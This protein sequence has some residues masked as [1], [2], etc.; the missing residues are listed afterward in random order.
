MGKKTKRRYDH[1]VPQFYLRNFSSNKSIGFYNFKIKKFVDKVAIHDIGGRNYFNGKDIKLEKWFIDLE[2]TWTTIFNN[3]LLHEKVPMDSTEY[4]YLLMFVY[5]SDVRVAEKADNFRIAKSEEGRNLAKMM[6][7]QNKITLSDDEI[8]NLDVEIDMP[9]LTYI[10]GMK[11]M[12]QILSDLCPLI[13][14]NESRIG[15]VTS[16]VPVAKY[17]QWFVER[18]YKHPYGYG[19]V[20]FQCFVP[21]SPKICFCLYDKNVY[22]NKFSNKERIRLYSEANVEEL[23]KLFIQ[24][25]YEEVYYE[26]AT[27]QWLENNIGI[28]TKSERDEWILGDHRSEF[29][30]KVSERSVYDVVKLSMF[31]TNAIFKTAPFPYD[32]AGP[33]R[34]TAYEI[35]NQWG[36]T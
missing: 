12:I 31:K 19:H 8:E 11:D 23:N 10:Q 15:F 32:E 20:G 22:D 18:G 13:I 9:N 24:N 30:Q 26:I 35:M 34:K 36:D 3:I 2:G 17:N 21:L 7:T 5:L 27:R 28:R 25:A 29:I 1:Y 14:V 6:V 33:I 4:T 16:D